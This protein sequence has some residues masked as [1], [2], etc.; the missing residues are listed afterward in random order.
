MSSI[1]DINTRKDD[2]VTTLPYLAALPSLGARFLQVYIYRY[3]YGYSYS[4][5]YR[6]RYRYRY[7]VDIDIDITAVTDID[8]H[9]DIP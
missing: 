9:I 3:G 2:F 6:C 8:K 1:L 7:T 5:S 4:Y